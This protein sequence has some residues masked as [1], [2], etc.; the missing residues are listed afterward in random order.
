MANVTVGLSVLEERRVESWE[1]TSQ[2][3]AQGNASLALG[4]NLRSTTG[5]KMHPVIEGVELLSMRVA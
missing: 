1:G 5:N 3:L 4:S 2:T